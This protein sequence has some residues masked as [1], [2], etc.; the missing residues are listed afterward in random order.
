MSNLADLSQDDKVEIEEDGDWTLLHKAAFDGD[1]ETVMDLIDSE[2]PVQVL[3]WDL[4][5]TKIQVHCTS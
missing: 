5:L 1:D 2:E 3:H 4:L